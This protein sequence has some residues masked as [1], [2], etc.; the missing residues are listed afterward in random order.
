MSFCFRHRRGFNET[1]N[2]WYYRLQLDETAAKC[3]SCRLVRNRR[4]LILNL[5]WLVWLVYLISEN[6][7]EIVQWIRE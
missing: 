4:N 1:K 2:E 7:K 5:I 6:F 3:P